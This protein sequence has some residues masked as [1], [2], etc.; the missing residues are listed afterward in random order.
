M[1]KAMLL[2]ACGRLGIKD[3]GRLLGSKF[4]EYSPA[5][6]TVAL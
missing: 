6:E 5:F 2:S 4:G 3:I 1:K